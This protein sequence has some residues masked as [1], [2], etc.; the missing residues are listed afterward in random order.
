MDK[1]KIIDQE[2]TEDY[3]IYHADCVEGM[4]GLPDD[5]VHYSIY[6]P[7]F[8]SL[9]TYSNSD[10]DMGNSAS[11]TEFNDHYRFLI[12]EHFRT[13]MPGRIISVHCM[14]LPTTKQ[15]DGFIGL[16]DF[17]GEIIRMF[18]EEG[19][20]Y[21]SEVV[22]W[23]DPVVAMQR[24]KAVGLLHKTIEKDSSMSRMGIPDTLLMFRK[25][26]D[27]PEPVSGRLKIE[28]YA[29]EDK[30]NVAHD[31]Y[32]GEV[33]RWNSINIWQRYASPVWMDINQSN[34]LQFRNARDEDDEKHICPLQLDVIS[35]CLQL[36]SNPGDTILSPFGGIG[37]E[38]Y[39]A[40]K[41]HRKPILFELK[42]SYFAMQKKNMHQAIVERDTPDLFDEVAP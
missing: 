1:V 34:T 11:R 32:N 15:N 41:M 40:V 36:W 21:H 13:H 17:R 12:K 8:A 39:M 33:E 14:N 4:K 6:S 37:S 38:G 30:P 7:P 24:T 9:F 18:L 19:F 42:D 20:I 27:N 29:G 35:R 31:A 26:G 5:S 10:R 22:I 28:E 25:P 16:T 2:V 3:A 23:K